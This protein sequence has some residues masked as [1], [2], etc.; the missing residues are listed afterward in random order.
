MLALTYF[1]EDV[2]AKDYFLLHQGALIQ[3]LFFF[4]FFFFLGGI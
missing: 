1:L 3:N 4:L 2:S